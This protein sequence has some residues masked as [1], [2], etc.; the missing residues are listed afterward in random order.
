[1]ERTWTTARG[2]AVK[3]VRRKSGGVREHH[4]DGEEYANEISVEGVCT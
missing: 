1:V 3:G 4:E 2:N